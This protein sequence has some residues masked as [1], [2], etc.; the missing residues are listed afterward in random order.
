[1][2]RRRYPRMGIASAGPRKMGARE[3]LARFTVVVEGEVT[4]RQYLAQV[5][6]FVDTQVMIRPVSPG[7]DPAKMARRAVEDLRAARR[8]GALDKRDQFWCM[9]DV[10]DYGVGVVSAAAELCAKAG[11]SSVVSNPC[12]EVW[13]HAHFAFSTAVGSAQDV[14]KAL[15]KHIPGYSKHIDHVDLMALYSV[16]KENACRLDK[17]HE[18]AGNTP[19]SAPSSDVY[20]LVDAVVGAASL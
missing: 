15:S 12:F 1:M 16:A 5:E 20:R 13:L 8:T 18:A 6:K 11:V 14:A 10:D 3:P 7:T 17:H 19:G 9:F 4:E 2:A